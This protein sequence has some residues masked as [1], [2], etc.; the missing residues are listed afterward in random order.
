MAEP[1]R[2]TKTKDIV[3]HMKRYGVISDPVAREKYHTNRLS[4]IIFNL[5]N[6][7]YEI[8]TEECTGRDVYGPN[9][10]AKYRLLSAPVI[11]K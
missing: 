1:K 8:E 2:R 4:A 11:K 7:G 5:R 10:Y 6:R 9:N 3:K